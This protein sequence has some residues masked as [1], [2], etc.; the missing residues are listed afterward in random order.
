MKNACML[1]T[2]AKLVYMLN[3]LNITIYKKV[4]FNPNILSILQIFF[5]KDNIIKANM[6]VFINI[7]H[8]QANII[9]FFCPFLVLSNNIRG[10]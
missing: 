10:T 3:T 6:I 1:I 7:I 2:D 5:F 4:R 9:I 8:K